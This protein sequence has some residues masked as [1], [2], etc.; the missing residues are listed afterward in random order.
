MLGVG[1]LNDGHFDDV[2]ALFHHVD[3]DQ[4]VIAFSFILN[5]IQLL[6][7]EAVDVADVSEPG[8][9][10]AQIFGHHGGFDAAALVM[11]AND[12][13]LHLELRHCVIHHT[14]RIQIEAVHHVGDIAM[15]KDFS[16]GGS[17]HFFC[18][19]PAVAAA[20]V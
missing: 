3:F 8:I 11:S 6:F 12:N 1:S 18:S 17:H 20:N 4:T 9:Q 10:D 5:E 2:H 13:M 14:D 19:N 15:H 16:G 7:V